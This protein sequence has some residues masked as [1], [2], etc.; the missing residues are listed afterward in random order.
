[1]TKVSVVLYFWVLVVATLLFAK[2][3][4]LA[5]DNEA[6]IKILVVVTI[7]YV[8]VVMISRSKGRALEEKRSAAGNR[9]NPFAP[10][11]KRKKKRK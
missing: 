6:I 8:G 5:E 9:K 3:A 10:S 11:E 2:T 1:M 4:G 7:L